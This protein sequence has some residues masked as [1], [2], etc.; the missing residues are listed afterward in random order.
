MEKY[1]PILWRYYLLIW[2]QQNLTSQKLNNKFKKR[3][4]IKKKSI[5]VWT[6]GYISFDNIKTGKAWLLN[7]KVWCTFGQRK[8]VPKKKISKSYIESKI[9]IIQ[10]KKLDIMEGKPNLILQCKLFPHSKITIV[11]YMKILTELTQIYV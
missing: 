2:D 10:S 6:E 9:F 4:S 1:F 8:C 11:L 7:S 3:K 5:C